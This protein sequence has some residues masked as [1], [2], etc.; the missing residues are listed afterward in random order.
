MCLRVCNGG[1]EHAAAET[2]HTVFGVTLFFTM[3][4]AV[5]RRRYPDLRPAQRLVDDEGVRKAR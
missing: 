4:T 2:A 1:F 5:S 3:C